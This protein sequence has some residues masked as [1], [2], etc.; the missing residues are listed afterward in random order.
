MKKLISHLAICID[1]LPL[2]FS[3]HIK[4]AAKE[5]LIIRKKSPFNRIKYCALYLYFYYIKPST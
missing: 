2:I 5:K 4:S 1:G 3:A